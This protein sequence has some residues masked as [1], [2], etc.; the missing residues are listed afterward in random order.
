[1]IVR[2]QCHQSQRKNDPEQE[3]IPDEENQDEEIPDR[4]NQDEENEEILDEEHQEEKEENTV[5]PDKDEHEQDEHY[6]EYYE[7]NKNEE[8]YLE[9]DDSLIPVS[10]KSKKNDPEQEYIPDEENQDEEIPDRDNQDEENEEILDEEH[11]EEKE[12]N[13]VIE[14]S[15]GSRRSTRIPKISQRLQTYRESTGK[16]YSQKNIQFSRILY[17]DSEVRVVAQMMLQLRD[18]PYG[19][20]RQH[21]VTYSLKKGLQKFGMEGR[22]AA[23]G[24]LQQL[25]DRQCFKPVSYNSLSET[26][27]KRALESLIFLTEKKDGRIKARY[28]ANGSPQRQWMDRDEVS[29][30]TV[31]TEAIMITGVIEALEGRDVATCD[32]PNAFVQT[33]LKEHDLDGHRTI[34]KIR[35]PLVDI[36]IEMDS[37]YEK[38]VVTRDNE[39]VLYVH[40]L[41]ALYGMLVSAMLFYK[42]LKNDL[43]GYGFKMNAYDPCVA[44]KIVRGRQMTVSWH[45]DDLKVSHIDPKAVDDFLMWIK[46]TYGRIGEVKITRGKYHEYLGMKFDYSQ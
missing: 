23:K 30:P 4:D 18:I 43:I 25:Y 32:I 14:D 37:E 26:E 19:I 6:E 44:N 20:S 31:T 22:A 9:D 36:L 12:E 29:S 41:K 27:R 42:K 39:A 38:F 5:I 45:V 1:M 15:Q 40:V 7:E 34:M 11:Q 46:R 28:C 17:N 24:E 13:T 2:S 16:N 3:Y 10:S 33:E 35:G 21:V 8:E